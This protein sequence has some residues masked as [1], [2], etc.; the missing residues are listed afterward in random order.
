FL[1][2]RPQVAQRQHPLERGKRPCAG[3][4]V[5]LSRGLRVRD[6]LRSCVQCEGPVLRAAC[7]GWY[8]YV[9]AG[10]SEIGPLAAFHPIQADSSQRYPLAVTKRTNLTGRAVRAPPPGSPARG[11]RRRGI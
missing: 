4:L 2:P 8:R 5:A 9:P 3:R 11:C 7:R 1:A 10:K 6:V